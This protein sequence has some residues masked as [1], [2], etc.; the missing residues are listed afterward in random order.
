M[1]ECMLGLE[2][3]P[4]L[5]ICLLQFMALRIKYKRKVK[6]HWRYAKMY[7]KMI[8]LCFALL[9]DTYNVDP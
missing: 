3:A 4:L 8:L 2:S 1:S 5:F 7:T 6:S 9:H